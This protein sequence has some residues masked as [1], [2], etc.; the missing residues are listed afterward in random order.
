MEL[1]GI[2]IP[3]L[4]QANKEIN[5]VFFR[6]SIDFVVKD[7]THN[8]YTIY[9]IKTSTRGWS[10]DD[11]KDPGKVNQVL[12]YKKFFAKSR[13]IPEE[14]IDVKFFVVKRKIPKTSDFY[15]SRIQEFS[16]ASGKIKMKQV[17]ED[18]NKFL[19]EVFNPDGS[20]QTKEYHKNV[21]N[22]C[23]YCPFNSNTELCD[24]GLKKGNKF[25]ID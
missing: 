4:I 2:E 3:L 1:I 5:N 22:S 24:R 9:D 18:F 11:K 19:F 10:Q 6:G 13:L 16:P 14:S 7:K 25:F 21:G 15:I 17:T 8:T 23:K 12:L 20:I